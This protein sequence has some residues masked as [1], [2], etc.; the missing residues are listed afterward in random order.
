MGFLP[1]AGWLEVRTLAT[2][3]GREGDSLIGSGMLFP[4]VAWSCTCVLDDSE[5]AGILRAEN[6]KVELGNWDMT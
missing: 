5:G 3:I 6:V 2:W 1:L 4:A